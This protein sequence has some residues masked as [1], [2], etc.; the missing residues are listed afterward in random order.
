M[1]GVGPVRANWRAGGGGGGGHWRAPTLGAV[2]LHPRSKP[3][4]SAFA[5]QAPQRVI[6]DAL[7]TATHYQLDGPA[8]FMNSGGGGNIHPWLGGG[9]Q[10]EAGSAGD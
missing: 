8:G 6:K 2:W 5:P 10:Q 3:L 1:G 7:P 9:I 4:A